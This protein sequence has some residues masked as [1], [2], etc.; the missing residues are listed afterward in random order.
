MLMPDLNLPFK[1]EPMTL[2]DIPAVVA[3]ERL[4]Y[5]MTWPATA[6]QYELQQNELAHYFVLHMAPQTLSP[7]EPVSHS[8]LPAR[9]E[10]PP[11]LWSWV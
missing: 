8:T 10:A 1:I 6:Y 11:R 2:L 9:P 7:H 3:I 4:S 5:S